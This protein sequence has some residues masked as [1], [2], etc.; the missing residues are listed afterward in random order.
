MSIRL[1]GT[2]FIRDDLS[3][4]ADTR[5]AML[6]QKMTQSAIAA[7]SRLAELHSEGETASSAQIA[8]SRNLPQPLVAKV[9]TTLTRSGLVSGSRGPGGGYQLAKQPADISLWDV[10]QLIEREAETA[11][12]F[13][14]GWCGVKEPCPLHDT[15]Y[16]MRQIEE[17]YL[18]ST[19]FDVFKIEKKPS[20]KRS[21]KSTK[22]PSKTSKKS[23]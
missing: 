20:R 1:P 9:M 15:L 4:V 21:K 3:I 22:K 2:I 17:N 7:M 14:P 23:K 10:V 11:C 18:K 6:H 5:E 13:G 8:D 16:A 12:P 19:T